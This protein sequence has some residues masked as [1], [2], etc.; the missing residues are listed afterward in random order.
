ML[1]RAPLIC[2]TAFSIH[3]KMPC[4]DIPLLERLDGRMHT[5]R[6]PLQQKPQ[7]LTLLKVAPLFPIGLATTICL[8]RQTGR[9]QSLSD[10]LKPCYSFS[11]W[12]PKISSSEPLKSPT[13]HQGK[14]LNYCVSKA[15]VCILSLH[16]T[17]R[18]MEIKRKAGSINIAV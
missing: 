16:M 8:W 4:T 15:A 7:Q 12:I 1:G 18:S 11:K 6:S 3:N 17:K 10:T 14:S 9:A 5:S 2:R 13:S